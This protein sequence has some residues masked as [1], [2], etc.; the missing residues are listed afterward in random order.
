MCIMLEP[1][2]VFVEYFIMLGPTQ[3]FGPAIPAVLEL[4]CIAAYFDW[5]VIPPPL[6]WSAREQMASFDQGRHHGHICILLSE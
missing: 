6:S 4:I 1:P 2:Q 5:S 3:V